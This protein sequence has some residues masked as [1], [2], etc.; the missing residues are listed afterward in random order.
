MDD[1]RHDKIRKGAESIKQKAF[2]NGNARFLS[3]D[4]ARVRVVMTNISIVTGVFRSVLNH[5]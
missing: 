5:R 3:T 2:M 4:E 1:A